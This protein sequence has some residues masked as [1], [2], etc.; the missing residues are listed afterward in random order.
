MVRLVR[1]RLCDLLGAL[2]AVLRHVL[3]CALRCVLLIALLCV[4]SC[5]PL[6]ALLSVL[7]AALRSA[8][9]CA[10]LRDLL[11]AGPDATR[12]DDWTRVRPSKDW[13]RE[14]SKK[15]PRAPTRDPG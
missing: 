12:P 2:L 11:R 4:L 6:C 5:V 13:F 15:D 7:L 14:K 10:L 3:L 1:A 8:L 9:P